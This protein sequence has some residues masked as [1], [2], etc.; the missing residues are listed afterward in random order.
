LVLQNLSCGYYLLYFA[1]FVPAFAIFRMWTLG[2]LRCA[3]AWAGL[4]AAAAVTLMLT[5]P[6]LLPYRD[7]QA[8]FGL[9]RPFGEVVQFSANV[10]SYATASP[11]LVLWGDLLRLH[12][13]AEGETFLGFVPWLLA[14]AALVTLVRSTR[15]AAA[16][17][18]RFRVLA[19]VLACL[20]LTQ[21]IALAGV[22]LFGGF[23]LGPISART[24]MRVLMQLVAVTGLLLAVSPR[25]RAHAGRAVRSPVFFFMAATLMAMWLSL[26]PRPQ[27][28]PDLVSGFGP[29]SALYEHVPGFNGVRVPARYAM[30]AGLFLAVTAGYGARA[31]LTS[32]SALVAGAVLI[33]LEGLAVPMDLNRTWSQHETMP[34]ARVLPHNRPPAIYARIAA[35][36][37]GSVITEFP[38]GDVAW[39]I[40]YV[41]YAAAHWQ[42]ITNG[43]S[44]AF[45]AG[46]RRRVAR[47]RRV[48]ADPEAA[49]QTLIDSGTTHVVLHRNAFAGA[50]DADAVQEWLHAHSARE[51]ERFPDGDIL[52]DLGS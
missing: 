5:V 17:V 31:L 48:A 38:F 15:G 14:L 13:H 43:Y 44:G 46:Y 34:P 9:E 7:A 22:V 49:W 42:P 25:A 26:G 47:L 2:T 21:L 30:I 18:T 35:L 20:A 23:E 45:P 29:Y 8:V 50:A 27:S 6:F 52:F 36:P 32:N 37:A 3:R 24:P 1:P 11:D 28:G 4:V 41:Y 33:L 16:P 10:W 19:W 40:R 51:L 39:E 12:P